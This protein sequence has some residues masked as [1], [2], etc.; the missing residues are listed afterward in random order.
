MCCFK[1]EN[2]DYLQF[3]FR[4]RRKMTY[5]LVQTYFASVFFVLVTWLCFLIPPDMFEVR[6]GIAMSTLLTLTAMFA[7][8]R[9][10]SQSESQSINLNFYPFYS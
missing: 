2:F 7:S 4:A 3:T 5:H 6:V 10:P 9:Y 1:E 8:I